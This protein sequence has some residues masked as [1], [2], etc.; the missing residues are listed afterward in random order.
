L[1]KRLCIIPDSGVAPNP[2]NW[3]Q[4]TGV[5]SS[6][7][8]DVHPTEIL[9]LTSGNGIVTDTGSQNVF[10][11]S[12]LRFYFD[13]DSRDIRVAANTEFTWAAGRPLWI[14]YY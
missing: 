12:N 2:N 13:A 4:I 8:F 6:A 5:V 10:I 11:E 9:K 3:S 1:V 7:A 14:D